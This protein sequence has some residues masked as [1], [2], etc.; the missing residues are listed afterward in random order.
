MNGDLAK[1]T[2]YF[3]ERQ[4]SADR[5]TADALLDL[6]G[7]AS[8]ATS[9]VIR[10]IAGFGPRHD[11]RSDVTLTGSEDPP[12]AIVAVDRSA[13]MRELAAQ[14]VGLVSRGLVTVES[15]RSADGPVPSG[16]LTRLTVYV[17]RGQR[18][19]GV[20]AYAAVCDTLRG[21][22]F[23]SAT[24][25]LGV[26]GTAHGQRHRARFFS[27]NLDVP[28]MVV[29]MGPT[30]RAVAA[31]DVLRATPGLQ[32]VTVE[33]V[34][35]SALDGALM[36]PPSDGTHPHAHRKLTLQTRGSAMHDGVPVH[37]ALITR[38]RA[39]HSSAG[40]T[41]FRG[42]WGF[43]G[44]EAPLTDSLLRIERHVPVTTVVV[45]TPERIAAC[46][47]VVDE[48]TARRGVVTVESVPGAVWIDDGVRRGAL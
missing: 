44:G 6:Y 29:G 40:A 37:R 8:V 32:M 38:L 43:Q 33:A 46:A 18:I 14:A 20:L 45:D 17:R 12:I 27:R 39:L 16:P 3:G 48:I 34:N 23:H 36:A 47:A 13:Q 31:I 25:Y 41:V 35:T 21:H 42:V 4:R 1:V 30:A 26:D 5:F 9:I 15:V 2:A 22:G 7:A 19:S 11:L 28:A 24:A 10:G